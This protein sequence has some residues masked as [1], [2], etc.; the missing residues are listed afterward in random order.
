MTYCEPIDITLWAEPANAVTNLVFIV[1]A[2]AIAHT[3]S[4]Y[5][6]AMSKVWELWLLAGLMAAIGIGSFLW[7]TIAT[8]WAAVTEVVPI[9]L[10]INVFLLSFLVRIVKLGLRGM[11]LT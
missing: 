7:H 3:L 5:G 11:A 4:R 10:F 8:P 6:Q 9:L 1:A 2:F